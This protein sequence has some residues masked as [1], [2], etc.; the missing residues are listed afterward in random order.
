MHAMT[1]IAVLIIVSVKGKIRPKL[2]PKIW[3]EIFLFVNNITVSQFSLSNL[4][5]STLFH[6]GQALPPLNNF[7]IVV[8]WWSDS[9]SCPKFSINKMH[10]WDFSTKYF[11]NLGFAKYIYTINI[12]IILKS[13]SADSILTIAMNYNSHRA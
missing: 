8:K 5:T 4:K 6:A 12:H 3:K 11:I 13:I 2:N 1:K 10:A 7:T 9:F